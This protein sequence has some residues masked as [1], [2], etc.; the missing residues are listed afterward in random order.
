[1]SRLER[2]THDVLNLLLA[3][4]LVLLGIQATGDP[5]KDWIAVAI[6]VLAIALKAINPK[7]T[8]YGVGS[9]AE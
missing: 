4:V 2:L 1:M 9:Q 8:S 5:G 7:D 3:S 6:S